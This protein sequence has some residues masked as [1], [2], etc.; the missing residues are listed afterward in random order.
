MLDSFP[1]LELEKSVLGLFF[2]HATVREVLNLSQFY[3]VVRD[4]V[5]GR[6]L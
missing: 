4:R 1:S 6:A 3:F 2:A 5:A